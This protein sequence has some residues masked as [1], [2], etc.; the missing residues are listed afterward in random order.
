MANK[1]CSVISSLQIVRAGRSEYQSL[2][3]FHYR[4]CNL[5]PYAAVY[6]ARDTNRS[7]IRHNSIAGVIVYTT[8]APNLE[9]RRVALG[10]MFSGFSSRRDAIAMVNRNIRCIS[11]VIVDPRYRGAGVGTMLVRETLKRIDFPIVEAMAVMGRV[12][13]FFEKAG[14]AAYSAGQSLRCKRLIEAFSVAGIDEDMFV[15]SALVHENLCELD[16]GMSKF[17]DNEIKRFLQSYKKRKHMPHSIE[18][19]A[20]MVNR[21]TQRPVYYLWSNPDRK[22][23]E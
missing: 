20:Y 11:R 8:A 5:G 22:V 9:L 6:V 13:P 15:D 16:A 10:D 2:S 7:A 3:R 18:R 19:T 23:H 14:M 4:D 1:K 21:L 17:I 12:N